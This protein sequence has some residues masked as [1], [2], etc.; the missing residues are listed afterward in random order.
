MII[1]GHSCH[2]RRSLIKRI[3]HGSIRIGKEKID[4]AVYILPSLK[5]LMKGTKE[6]CAAD[7]TTR[8]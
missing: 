4:M 2:R 7:E 1:T 8:K 5:A 6:N 3:E